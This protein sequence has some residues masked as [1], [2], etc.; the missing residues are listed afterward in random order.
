[1]Y[2]ENLYL[3]IEDELCERSSCPEASVA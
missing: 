2:T 1:L 3:L